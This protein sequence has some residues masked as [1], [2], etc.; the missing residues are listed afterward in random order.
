VNGNIYLP[1]QERFVYDAL[2]VKHLSPLLDLRI[3]I[4]TI[5]ILVRGEESALRH[6]E[7]GTEV[8]FVW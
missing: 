2:Y 4:K 6:P 3:I 8:P 7:P 1:W 5:V